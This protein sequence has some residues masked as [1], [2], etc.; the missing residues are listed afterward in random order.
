MKAFQY[1]ISDVA[2]LYQINP[3]TL[4]YYEQEG[5]LVP[6][7]SENGYR[8][9]GISD[10]CIINIIRSLRGLGLPL[11]Q[12]RQYVKNRNLESTIKL[13]KQENALLQ[14]RITELEEERKTIAIRQQRISLALEEPQEQVLF[15]TIDDRTCWYSSVPHIH[16]EE[17][18]FYLNTMVTR[19]G[20]SIDRLINTIAA[21]SVVDERLIGSNRRNLFI[22]VFA[23][24]GAG[25]AFHKI[26]PGGT[27]ACYLYR[28]PYRHPE[29][30]YSAIKGELEKRRYD[31][32]GN[33]I[34]L[35]RVDEHD[36]G[37]I[38]EY[39]TEIQFPVRKIE[40]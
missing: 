39:I 10:I 22:G 7:R 5:L 3:D 14:Q 36:T 16:E 37:N 19:E 38:S 13:I 33:P 11:E 20:L 8:Y 28:G 12:I 2:N 6:K 21:G 17:V 18:D 25:E 30:I 27:Y 31:L 34:Q 1:R 9:Y 29:D 23:L 4:R 15:K 32:A 24:C 35:Y 26:L 40:T